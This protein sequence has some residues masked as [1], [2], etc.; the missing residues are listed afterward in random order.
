MCNVQVMGGAVSISL[1]EALR[2]NKPKD[3]R[4]LLSLGYCDVDAKDKDGQ[5]SLMKACRDGQTEIVSILLKAGAKPNMYL[6]KNRGGSSLHFA[7]IGESIQC[8][9]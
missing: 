2:N 6:H 7:S 5:T 1:Q 9:G 4:R 3:V 8:L